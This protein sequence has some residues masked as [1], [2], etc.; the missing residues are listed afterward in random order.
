MVDT[1]FKSRKKILLIMILL[2]VL[3]GF[4]NTFMNNQ[5]LETVSSVDIKRYCGKWYEIASYPQ[6][7]QKDCNCTTAEYTFTDKGYVIVENKCNRGSVNGK[8][9]SIKGKV[10]VEENTGNAKLKVQFFWPFKAKYWIIDLADD[11]S[12]AVVS[13]PNKK[14]LWILSRTPQMN[15]AVYQ[16]ILYRLQQKGFDISKLQMTKQL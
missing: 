15:G 4:S 6:F 2:L 9:S 10:F 5:T 13:N 3:T 16:K 1:F 7:F 11:Y 14:Y 8:V 12:Y